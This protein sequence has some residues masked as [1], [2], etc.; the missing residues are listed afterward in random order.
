MIRRADEVTPL[1][2]VTLGDAG[3]AGADL[4][5]LAPAAGFNTRSHVHGLGGGATW[6][7]D[8]RERQFG[9]QCRYHVDFCHVGDCLA[10]A[11]VCATNDPG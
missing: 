9:M 5:R 7:E 4:L 6:I 3:A 11:K 2:A 10:A 1:F 8:Q